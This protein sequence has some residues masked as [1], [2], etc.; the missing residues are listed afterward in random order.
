MLCAR[1]ANGS[2]K[3]FFSAVVRAPSPTHYQHKKKKRVRPFFKPFNQSDKRFKSAYSELNP[4]PGAY[5][6]AV[7]QNRNVQMLHTFGG[8]TKSVPHVDIKCTIYNSL[9]V[10]KLQC[11]PH[12]ERLIRTLICIFSLKNSV[13]FAT[14]HPLAISIV[15]IPVYSVADVMNTTSSGKRNSRGRKI[16]VNIPI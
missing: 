8:R 14:K 6:H 2:K 12:S 3:F 15:S 4:G 5:E 7:Q 1:R 9:K 11:S 10:E 13:R 16:K